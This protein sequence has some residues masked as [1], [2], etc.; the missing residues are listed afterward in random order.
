[1]SL[2]DQ[3]EVT[4]ELLHED[5]CFE[6]QRTHW[7]RCRRMSSASRDNSKPEQKCMNTIETRPSMAPALKLGHVERFVRVAQL[8][9]RSARRDRGLI[10]AID[11]NDRARSVCKLQ[12]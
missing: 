10:S 2:K 1:M 12:P 8:S 7:L 11:Q 9:A 4:L 3:R 6:R 5:D